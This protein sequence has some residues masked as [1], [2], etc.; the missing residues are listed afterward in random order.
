E[1]V[2]AASTIEV[3]LHL[4]VP[5]E[6]TTR[7][8]AEELEHLIYGLTL[9]AA[10]A[11]AGDAGPAPGGSANGSSPGSSGSIDLF[12]RE[13]TIE[14]QAWLEIVRGASVELA[15]E[16]FDLQAVEAIVAKNGGEM[17][18][19]ERRGGGTELVVALPVVSPPA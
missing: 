16:R 7:C 2:R 13:R 4:A 11:Q 3:D 1:T 19:S 17:A 12:V 15:G 6:L 8:T 18:H 5:P 10:S 14:G 9:D